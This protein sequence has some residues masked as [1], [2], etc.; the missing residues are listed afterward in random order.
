MATTHLVAALS[1]HI[2]SLAAGLGGGL[3]NDLWEEPKIRGGKIYLPSSS[4]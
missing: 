1:P 3:E 2:S 4:E